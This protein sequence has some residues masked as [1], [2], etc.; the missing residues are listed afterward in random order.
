MLFNSKKCTN[1]DAS[2]AVLRTED[3]VPSRISVTWHA[4]TSTTVY[5]GHCRLKKYRADGGG[6]ILKKK[7]NPRMFT[8]RRKKK[9]HRYSPRQKSYCC[10]Q[11][12]LANGVEN[13]LALYSFTVHYMIA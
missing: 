12:V 1:A 3:L 8:R 6:D 9:T 13:L 10:L 7:N 11:C 5:S 2:P 4:V